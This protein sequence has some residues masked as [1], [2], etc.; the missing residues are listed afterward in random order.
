MRAR[1]HWRKSP[2]RCPYNEPLNRHVSRDIFAMQGSVRAS[3]NRK[4]MPRAFPLRVTRFWLI[5]L[6]FCLW[7]CVIT[8]RLFTLQIVRHQEFSE[9]AQKQQQRTFE[10]APR[11]GV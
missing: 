4:T 1:R 7:A 5:C 6:F 9:R 11:R 3:T 2:F 8:A 10:V